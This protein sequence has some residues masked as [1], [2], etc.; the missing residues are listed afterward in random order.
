[1]SEHYYLY[2]KAT[3]EAVEAVATVGGKDG[4]RIEPDALGAFLAYHR[5]SG[6]LELCLRNGENLN[7]AVE[8]WTKANYQD[9]A[10][11]QP[12]VAEAIRSIESVRKWQHVSQ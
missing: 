8:V 2:C 1:M 10:G 3:N 12:K 7:S 6:H 11:R 4:P 5:A 9:L